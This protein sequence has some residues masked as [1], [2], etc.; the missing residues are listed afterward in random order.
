MHPPTHERYLSEYG[1]LNA[2]VK[3]WRCECPPCFKHAAD[4]ACA[5]ACDLGLC[6]EELGVCLPGDSATRAAAGGRGGGGG[7]V[8]V[9]GFLFGM[10]A[11][12]GVSAG[13]VYALQSVYASQRLQTEV[14]RILDDYIP[15]SSQPTNASNTFDSLGEESSGGLG[16]SR[17]P[18]PPGRLSEV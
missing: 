16:G 3:P 10:V 2:T 1:R 15:L 12:A 9:V 4:G 11:A 13:V 6:D 5:P 8:G 18:T 7:G 17:G 14:H